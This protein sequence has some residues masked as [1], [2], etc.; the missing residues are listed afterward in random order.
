MGLFELISIAVALAMDAFAVSICQ[1]LQ[2]RCIVRARHVLII[3]ALFGGFQAL[4]PAIGF[5]LGKQFEQY[6][7]SVD[8]WIAFVL[9]AFL[10]GKMILDSLRD[11]DDD[12]EQSDREC[13]IY[14][15]NIRR[16]LVM[17]VATSID[18]LAIGITFAFLGVQIA[19]ASTLIGLVTF[20]I[21]IAGVLIGT[22]FGARYRSKATLAGGVVLVLIGAKILLEHLNII[23]F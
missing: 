20:A 9:L 3:A 2:M 14:S 22:R 13:T 5:L 21:C 7:T 15:L 8:H 19:K 17:A 18:A 1:G 10:G 4:M 16:L 12:K 6:I 11:S 23:S